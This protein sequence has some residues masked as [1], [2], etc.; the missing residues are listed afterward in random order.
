MLILPKG[1]FYYLRIDKQ[2]GSH[3]LSLSGFGAPQEHGQ[4]PFTYEIG[5]VD[6]QY[7]KDLGVP[8]EAN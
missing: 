2:L 3:L 8:Q 5:L 6:S 1:Y 4:R 7:A